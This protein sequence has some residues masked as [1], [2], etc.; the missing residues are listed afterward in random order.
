MQLRPYQDESVAKIREYMRQ[1]IKQILLTSPTGSGKTLE[2][3]HMLKTAAERGMSSWFVVHRRE[4]INQSTRAF[5][6]EG[7]PHG[8]ISANFESNRTALIQIASVQTLVRRFHKYR[9]PNLIVWDECHHIAANSWSKIFA[10][11]PN[12]YH[13][14]LTATPERLDGTGLDKWFRAMVNGPSVSWLIENGYLSPYKIY[15]PGEID[16]S[17]VRTRMGDYV[18]SE[19]TSIVDRPSITG[20]AIKHYK[21]LADG[22]RA[23]VFCASVAHSKHVVEQFKQAGVPAEHVDGETDTAERD[24][25]IRRFRDG[26]IKV[27]SN[28]ELFGEG[29][30]VPCIEVAILLRP[31]KSLGL[32]LQ[33][34]GRSLRPSPG[35]DH[36]IILDHAN[37]CREHGLP[38]DDRMWTLQGRDKKERKAPSG[39][40]ICPKCF[41]ASRRGPT[42]CA[43]CGHIFAVESREVEQRDGE[44]SEVDTAAVRWKQHIEQ[45]QTRTLEG[46]IALGKKRG[47]KNPYWWAQN[48]IKHRAEKMVR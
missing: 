36:A 28:V 44:L 7:V 14:G 47:Y 48:V 23:V 20:D 2:T 15:A 18:G 43:L 45:G 3:S 9:V 38:D 22:K 4:L 13:I 1:G 30:D 26:E 37:N 33:Q 6:G 12:A 29:F 40:R 21:K 46:L 24:M 5:D 39:V 17:K 11:F 8:I 32:Y 31:T 10:Q 19:L 42:K 35:K 41:G 16:L 27:L 25:A 34:V